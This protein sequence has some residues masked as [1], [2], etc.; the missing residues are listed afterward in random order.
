M[1]RIC[2]I[3]ISSNP[4]LCL[5]C[6]GKAAANGPFS[7]NFIAISLISVRDQALERHSCVNKIFLGTRGTLRGCGFI[8]PITLR[9][10]SA[11][12][13]PLVFEATSHGV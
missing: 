7:H 13:K 1:R 2:A 3:A 9:V 4:E 10:I 5:L 12:Q 11:V 8:V 6:P